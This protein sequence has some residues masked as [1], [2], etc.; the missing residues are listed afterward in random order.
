MG[1]HEDAIY[2]SWMPMGNPMEI[3]END[4]Y[5]PSG[6]VGGHVQNA[7]AGPWGLG[8]FGSKNKRLG[9]HTFTLSTSFVF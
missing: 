6:G 8:F 1:S 5:C 2:A 4:E 3:R 7:S 9:E